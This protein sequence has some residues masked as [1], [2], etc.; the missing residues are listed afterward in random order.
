MINKKKWINS[1]KKKETGKK[2]KWKCLKI[3]RAMS[4]E[5]IKKVVNQDY[6]RG[7]EKSVK[8]IIIM[9]IYS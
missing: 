4:L 6:S 8:I 1:K 9:K 3:F 2:K 7:K 5:V